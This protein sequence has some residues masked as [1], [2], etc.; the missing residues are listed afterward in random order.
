MNIEISQV[1][2]ISIAEII[3]DDILMSEAQDALDLIADCGYSYPQ[4]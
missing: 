4:N 3:S 2:G 1:N